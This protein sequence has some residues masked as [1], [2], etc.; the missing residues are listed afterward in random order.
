MSTPVLYNGVTYNIPGLGDGGYAQGPGNL[1]LYLI[2]L[3]A[4]SGGIT[5]LTGDVT[6]AGPGSAAATLATVNSNVGSFLS[7]NITVDAKG[8]ITAAA[9]GSGGGGGVTSITGTAHQVIASA[10]TGAVTLSLPQSIDTSSGVSFGGVAL[11]NAGTLEFKDSTNTNFIL[12][13]TPGSFTTQQII[14]PSAVATVGAALT[15]VTASAPNYTTQWVTPGS[16]TSVI[17]GTGTVTPNALGITTFT[18]TVTGVLTINGPTNGFD[19]QKITF[20]LLQDSSGHTVTFATGAGNFRFGSTIPSFTASGMNLTDYVGAI[21]N[22]AA[23][24]WD[25]VSVSQGF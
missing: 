21:W 4:T 11:N 10:S 15:V 13:E 9:N 20:R 14:L 7:A 19:G 2:A 5:A 1:S 24:F 18:T 23:G 17:A 12:L 16:S 8:R 25:L 6:A 3:A 22:T